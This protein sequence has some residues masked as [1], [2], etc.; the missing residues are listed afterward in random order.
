MRAPNSK[1]NHIMKNSI[2][3]T[4]ARIREGDE[5]RNGGLQSTGRLVYRKR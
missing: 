4:I 2:H 1:I 3:F 5:I